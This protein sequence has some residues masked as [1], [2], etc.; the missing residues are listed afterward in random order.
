MYGTTATKT[1]RLLHHLA[2]NPSEIVRY[3]S[4]NFRSTSPIEIG[5]P[6][7]SYKAIDFLDSEITEK[8]I[9]VEYGSGGST[10]FFAQHAKKVLAFEDDADWANA[11]KSKLDEK[12][13]TNAEVRNVA[14]DPSSAENF[15]ASEMFNQKIPEDATVAIVDCQEFW[16]E[17]IVRPLLLKKLLSTPTSLRMIVLDDSWRYDKDSI[18]LALKDA[19]KHKWMR[20]RG[21]GPC[22][23]GVTSTDVIFPEI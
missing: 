2:T 20:F 22:R 4:H 15:V 1:A 16:P 17:T 8:D 9:I 13:L 19:N 18:I 21:T 3:V 5:V 14:I 11:V 7:M 12:N 10:V 6:W 23:F